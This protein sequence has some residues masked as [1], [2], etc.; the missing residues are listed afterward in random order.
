MDLTEASDD[1]LRNSMHAFEAA[2]GALHQDLEPPLCSRVLLALDGSNQD[3]AS[4]GLA[5]ALTER[6]GARLEVWRAGGQDERAADLILE[7]ANA[8]NADLIVLCAPFRDDFSALGSDSVG[9]HLDLLMARSPHPMLVIRDPALASPRCFERVLLPIVLRSSEQQAAAAWA[10]RAVAPGG[11]IGIVAV[12][13]EELVRRAAWLE[14]D[15][16]FASLSEEELA[17]L[18]EPK[19]AGL[20]AAVQRYASREHLGCSVRVRQGEVVPTLI[21]LAG[22]GPHIVVVPCPRDPAQVEFHRVQSL[23][24]ASS[25]PVWIV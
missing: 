12:I 19:N 24:R 2:L 4:E 21:E 13:D 14:G 18:R 5:H 7:R 11:S 9:T 17:G 23:V 16:D 25:W 22:T 20:I 10:L 3:A 1:E 6:T 8:L 15:A